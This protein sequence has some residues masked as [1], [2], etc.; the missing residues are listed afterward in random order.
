ML[1]VEQKIWIVFIYQK[2]N[3]KS[4]IRAGKYALRVWKS[5]ERNTFFKNQV[6]FVNALL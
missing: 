2:K 1:L 4:T 5:K 6:V 3:E